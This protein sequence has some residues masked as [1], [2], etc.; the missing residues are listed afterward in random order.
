VT[1]TTSVLSVMSFV[2]ASPVQASNSAV[3]QSSTHATTVSAR[4]K[5]ARDSPATP[6]PNGNAS[7]KEPSGLAP[8]GPSAMTGYAL[9]YL[10]DFGGTSL[11]PGWE[12]FTG[13]PGGD[14][15]GQWSAGHVGVGGGL[16]QLS[17]W[18]DPAYGNG[19]VSG[20]VCQCGV[21]RVYGAYFVRSRVSGPGPTQVESLWPV[22][23]WPPEI[24]FNESYGNTD[25][26]MATAHYG[27]AN[28]QVHQTVNIDMTQWHT[29][30]VI[31]T[32]NSLTYTVDGN[33]WG[34]VTD[35]NAISNQLMTLDLQQQTWC[36][37][38]WACPTTPQSMQVDWVAEYTP[39]SITS[40][41]PVTHENVVVSPFAAQSSELTPLLRSQ[42]IKL[43]LHIKSAGVSHVSLVG[44][45]DQQSLT[46][47]GR[48]LSNARALAVKSYLRHQL[49]SLGIRGVSV[50]AVG[51][52]VLTFISTSTSAFVHGTPRRVVASLS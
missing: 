25:Y 12:V 1:L 38:N 34:S 36:S 6:Y 20:G 19:W 8:P 28:L 15:G 4:T 16:L 10:N 29:W 30:G 35:P 11:P 46:P 7:A 31:W 40:V 50:S 48:A 23:G 49:L 45:G 24:D 18:Q 5:T 9:S 37:A 21:A 2:V 51:S 47:K 41:S 44:F 27:A 43:A 17:T 33:V 39:I 22:Q 32:P 13:V 42:I 3:H 52:Q 26:S 14:P